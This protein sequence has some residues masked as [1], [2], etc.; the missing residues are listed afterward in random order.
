MFPYVSPNH[1]SPYIQPPSPSKVRNNCLTQPEPNPALALFSLLL[2]FLVPICSLLDCLFFSNL[3]QLLLIKSL[4][5]TS[6][7]RKRDQH[8]LTGAGG[9][10]Y[11]WPE[12]VTEGGETEGETKSNIEMTSKPVAKTNTTADGQPE[13]QSAN[14]EYAWCHVRRHA[15][16]SLSPPLLNT[17]KPSLGGGGKKSLCEWEMG[18]GGGRLPGQQP[19]HGDSSESCCCFLIPCHLP[20]PSSSPTF[21]GTAMHLGD[22]NS[23]FWGRW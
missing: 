3:C 17:S 18:V 21:K 10:V 9:G 22:T 7:K 12:R 1:P 4:P 20:P 16:P 23:F 19:H 6:L 13:R 5:A 15:L 14:S 11:W 2:S 8:M